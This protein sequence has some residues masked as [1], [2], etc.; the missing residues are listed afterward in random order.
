MN[1]ASNRKATSMKQNATFF[2]LM[3]VAVGIVVVFLFP[4]LR[5]FGHPW[6]M[7]PIAA[8]FVLL[9]IYGRHN[10]TPKRRPKV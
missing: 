5:D 10:P 2:V 6:L 3:G 4:F 8:F 7:A 9:V 1:G